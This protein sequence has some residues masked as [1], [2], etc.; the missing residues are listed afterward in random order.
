MYPCCKHVGGDL[1]TENVQLIDRFADVGRQL[2]ETDTELPREGIGVDP[3][4]RFGFLDTRGQRS[5]RSNAAACSH[6]QSNV[7]SFDSKG[8]AGLGFVRHDLV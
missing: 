8:R 1:A 5:E 2:A 4:A 3:W 7:R 6:E